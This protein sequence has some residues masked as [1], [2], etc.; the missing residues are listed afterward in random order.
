VAAAYKS[1]M[2]T[3][4]SS[5]PAPHDPAGAPDPKALERRFPPEQHEAILQALRTALQ[6]EADEKLPSLFRQPEAVALALTT[7]EDLVGHY[8]VPKNHDHSR[9]QAL[10]HA[11]KLYC[12][13]SQ[14]SHAMIA[15]NHRHTLDMEP[16]DPLTDTDRKSGQNRLRTR[17]AGQRQTRLASRP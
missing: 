3:V 7:F 2:T 15:C 12:T 11:L 17:N 16:G 1:L 6:I 14:Y 5:S 9:Y 4:S 8:R 13:S 10:E